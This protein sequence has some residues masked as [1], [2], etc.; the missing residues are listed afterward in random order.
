MKIL[1]FHRETLAQL[2]L[3]DL[4]ARK[5]PRVTVERLDL[6]VAL[7]KLVLL[8]PLALL[9]RREPPVVMELL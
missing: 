3:P 5:D 1:S 4:V 9:E 8:D 2:D 7:V 6:W